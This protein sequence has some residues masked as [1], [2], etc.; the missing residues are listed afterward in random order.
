MGIFKNNN[1]NIDN[2]VMSDLNGQNNLQN[3]GEYEQGISYY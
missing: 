3:G 2:L 1:N